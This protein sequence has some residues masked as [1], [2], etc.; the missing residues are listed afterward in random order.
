MLSVQDHPIVQQLDNEIVQRE[1]FLAEL[2][3][4][5]ISLTTSLLRSTYDNAQMICRKLYIQEKERG[6]ALLCGYE[7]LTNQQMVEQWLLDQLVELNQVQ[8]ECPIHE[9]QNRLLMRLNSL[10]Q[11]STY[12]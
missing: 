8:F 1:T 7:F 4:K 12:Y 6:V 5:R 10:Q 2:Q 11:D 3:V 9:L